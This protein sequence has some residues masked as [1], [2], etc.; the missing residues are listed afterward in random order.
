[1]A[2]LR[3]NG[4]WVI[5]MTFVAAMML[6]MV[7]LWDW[8]EGLRPRFVAMVLIFWT[9]ALPE[10]VGVTIGWRGGVLVVYLVIEVHQRMRQFPLWQQALSV[11]MLIG[12]QQMIVLWVN[13]MSGQVTESWW[14]WITPVTSMLLWPWVFGL[15]RTIRRHFHVR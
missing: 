15:L 5:I 1:M 2:Q 7:P 14:Y 8:L 11:M 3:H 9:F 13:G 10:R 12:L 6:V 4:G